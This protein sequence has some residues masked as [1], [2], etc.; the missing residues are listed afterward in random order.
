MLEEVYSSYL[1]LADEIEWKKYDVNELFRAYIEHENDSV[2]K[3]KYYSGIMCRVWGYIGRLYNQC[4]KHVPIEQ[5]YDILVNTINYIL[6]KR[7]WEDENNSLYNNPKAPEMAFKVV[8]KRERGILLAN[9]NADKRRSNFNSLSIDALREDYS[10]STD[11]M[12]YLDKLTSEED[13]SNEILLLVSSFFSQDR[14]LEGVFIDMIAF[15][16]NSSYSE[17]KVI[18]KVCNLTEKDFNYYAL[19]YKLEEKK[20]NK[21]LYEIKNTSRRLLGIKLKQLLDELKEVV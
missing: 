20:Y 16:L 10:D 19:V 4:N 14:V 13:R 18:S 6:K 15:G 11:G 3:D 1:E 9:L 8:L 21:L 5:C 17:R 2:L 7:V 12:F